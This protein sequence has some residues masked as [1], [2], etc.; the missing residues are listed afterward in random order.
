MLTYRV[1]GAYGGGREVSG[2]PVNRSL[3]PRNPPATVK[4]MDV[5]E[6]RAR[7]EAKLSLART[8]LQAA[9]RHAGLMGNEDAYEDIGS[10]VQ[11]VS[12]L[13]KE[14]LERKTRKPLR[15][16]LQILDTAPGSRTPS[17]RDGLS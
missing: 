17:W 9:Q 13:V 4:E 11:T 15:G 3:P 12:A 14:S 1:G 10:M 8:H 6:N 2:L 7:Y 16:Q 5:H